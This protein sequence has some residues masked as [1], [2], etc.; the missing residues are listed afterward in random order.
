MFGKIIGTGSCLPKRRVSNNDLSEFLETN[1]EWIRERTGIGF[2]HVL[3][4]ET[5]EELAIVAA[6]NALDAAGMSGEEVD[7]IVVSTLSSNHM[8]PSVSCLVQRGIGAEHAL[9]FDLNAACTGFLA[10]YNT[11]QA[12]ISTGVIKTGLV[13]GAEGLSRITEWADRSSCILFG[14]GAGAAVLREDPSAQ[15]GM[16][17]HADGAKGDALTCEFSYGM[18][19]GYP[20]TVAAVSEE[21][22]RHR[23]RMQMNGQEVF[24]FAIRQVPAGIHELLEKE[25]MEMDS[26]DWFLLHQANARIIEGAA[27]RLGAPIEKFPMNLEEYGNTSSASIPILLD[28]MVREGKIQRGQCLV[29]A[30]FGGGLTWG[31]TKVIF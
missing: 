14:D 4:N 26:V 11:V 28:E 16:I 2:R 7:M 6:K 10:A 24:R 25:Q 31:A 19:N 18:E 15:F 23:T 12:Y 17:M 1:D 30:G 29:L 8:L 27:K 5:P 21:E 13:I 9:C 20:G 22:K 3:E